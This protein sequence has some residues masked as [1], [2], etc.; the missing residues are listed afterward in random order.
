MHGESNGTALLDHLG[1]LY[2]T[3]TTNERVDFL[4]MLFEGHLQK[5]DSISDLLLSQ[6][7]SLYPEEEFSGGY[8]IQ[9][10]S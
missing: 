6:S 4:I 5:L 8:I 10:A 1:Q 2:D 3:L 9:R 7:L